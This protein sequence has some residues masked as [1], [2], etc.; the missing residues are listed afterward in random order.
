MQTDRTPGEVY[1]AAAGAHPAPMLDPDRYHVLFNSIDEGFCIVEMIFADNGRPIDYRFL[2][3]NPAFERHTGLRNAAGRTVR[4]LELD[5]EDHWFEI[6]GQVA[7]TGESVRF[8]NQANALE[9][10]WFDVNAFRI[11]APEQHLVGILFTDISQRKQLER[12]QYDFVAMTNHDLSAPISV[13]RGRAQLMR[14]REQFDPAGLDAIIEQTRRMERLLDDLRQAIKAGAGWVEL[15]PAEVDLGQ[16]ARVAAERSRI[17]SRLHPIEVMTPATPVIGQWDRDRLNQ[18]LDNLIGNA[19]KHTPAGSAI[20]ITVQATGPTARLSVADTGPGIPS[21]TLPH[22]FERFYRASPSRSAG[23]LGL[24]LYI[25]RMLVEAHRG[26][27][28]AES[29]PGGGASIHVELPLP[30]QS[31]LPNGDAPS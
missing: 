5:L 7:M 22:L 30:A 12:L 9:S 20:T 18:V 6:Y 13:V 1:P 25:V 28:W 15:R 16:I 26:R 14:R 19:Q 8:T 29:P 27:V 4:E 3:I 11:G 10:R 17:L 23:G 2:E 24:G 21:G 31:P